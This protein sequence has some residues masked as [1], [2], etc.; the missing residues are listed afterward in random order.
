MRQMHNGV[1]G[2]SPGQGSI[3]NPTGWKVEILDTIEPGAEYTS[4]AVPASVPKQPPQSEPP[5]SSR[6]EVAVNPDRSQEQ[7]AG[8]GTP[9]LV[10]FGDGRCECVAKGVEGCLGGQRAICNAADG[11]DYAKL[12]EL[13]AGWGITIVAEASQNGMWWVGLA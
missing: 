5:A 6:P 13:R 1:C 4:L 3:Q 8:P 10:N 12:S 7:S 11:A 2:V 9:V